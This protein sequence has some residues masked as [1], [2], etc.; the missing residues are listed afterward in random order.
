MSGKSQGIDFFV[1]F[2]AGT[3]NCLYFGDSS[4]IEWNLLD[5]DPN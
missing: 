3:E 4:P 2:R 1:Y 5:D